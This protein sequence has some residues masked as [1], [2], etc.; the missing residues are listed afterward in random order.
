[1][2]GPR[3]SVAGEATVSG[4]GLHTGLPV[5]LTFRRSAGGRGIVFRR[6]D[7]EG[8]PVIAARLAAVQASARRTVLAAGGVTVQTVEHVLAGVAALAIDDLVIDLDGPEPPAGDG[9]AAPFVDALLEAGVVPVR[10][11]TTRRTVSAPLSVQHGDAVYRV[12][13]G[14]GLLLDLTIDWAHPA[15]GRQTGRYEITAET[16]RDAL[17]GA[18][19]FG[20]LED[21]QRL[22]SQ[23]LARGASPANTVVLTRTGLLDAALRWPDEFVRHKAVDLLGDLALLG[24]RL[25]ATIEAQRPS[26]QGNIALAHAIDAQSLEVPEP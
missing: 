16:F 21:R 26:H 15:I 22:L 17:A 8:T 4:T 2:A 12:S 23:G 5:T 13:P 20:F 11:H 24:Y 1:M 3:R 10:G 14:D 25:A 7:C 18:R 6:T 19:T 9:S